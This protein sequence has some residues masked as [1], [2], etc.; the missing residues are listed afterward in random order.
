MNNLLSK[1]Y[2]LTTCTGSVNKKNCLNFSC[3]FILNLIHKIVDS[4]YFSF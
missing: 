3:E 4:G 2:D 1:Y